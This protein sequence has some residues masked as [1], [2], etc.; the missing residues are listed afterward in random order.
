MLEHQMKILSE[1]SFDKALFRNELMKAFKWLSNTELQTLC[2]WLK[3]NFSN[4][5]NDL[6]NESSL[7]LA[8]KNM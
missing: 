8:F 1:L 2:T 5:Y 4:L 7:K 6:M 3:N